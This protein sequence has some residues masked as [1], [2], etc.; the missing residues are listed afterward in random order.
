MTI[1]L[2]VVREVTTPRSFRVSQIASMFDVPLEE[3]VRREWDVSLPLDERD[4]QIGLITGPSGCGKSSVAQSLWPDAYTRG[5]DWDSETSILDNFGDR[6]A[7]DIVGA[8]TAVGFS[9]PPD[10]VK[11]YGALSTGQQMRADLARALLAPDL[12]VFDEFTSVV[13]RTVAKVGSAA[14]A[15]A[16]RRQPGRQF[17]AVS[18][19][20]DVLEWLTPDWVYE[21]ATNTFAWRSLRRPPIDIEI[22]RVHPTTAWVLFRAHHY[23]S[24]ALNPSAQCYVAMWDGNPVAFAAVLPLIGFKNCRRIS[25]IVVLPD[26]QGIGVGT[27][28]CAWVGQYYRSRGTRVRITSTHPGLVAHFNRSPDWTLCAQMRH[29][30]MPHAGNL[31][32]RTRSSTGRAVATFEYVACELG[33]HD[34]SLSSSKSS[35][36]SSKPT[37]KTVKKDSP[38]AQKPA[39]RPAA[40]PVANR[41]AQGRE[42]RPPTAATGRRPTQHRAGTARVSR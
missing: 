25:R 37:K 20:A 11:P 16:I 1:P 8:L 15:K 36:S 28:L 26:Y 9:S 19:H 18:C 42:K 39:Q 6:P 35:K 3:K 22:I 5:Y 31:K 12:V 23:L 30:G 14:L 34:S 29:G 33:A 17:I 2:H 10:W 38:H 32:G 13:D 41:T 4:W 21:P 24:A 7:K 40:R 27:M